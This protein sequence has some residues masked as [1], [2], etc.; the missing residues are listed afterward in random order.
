VWAV[1]VCFFERKFTAIKE[2]NI[3]SPEIAKAGSQNPQLL[4]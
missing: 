4:P 3:C 2:S 1:H